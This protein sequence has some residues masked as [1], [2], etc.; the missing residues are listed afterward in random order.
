MTDEEDPRIQPR[1]RIWQ[2]NCRKSLDNMLHLINNL[3]PDHFDLCLVQEP[4][5]D[6]LSRMRAPNG[7]HIVLPP[8]HNNPNT[9]ST[10]PT[11]AV[12]LVS[13]RLDTTGWMN[14]AIESPDATGIQIWGD[15]GTFWIFNVYVDCDHSRTI[16]AIHDWLDS[17]NPDNNSSATRPTAPPAL[18]VHDLLLGDF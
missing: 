16:H 10:S 3:D 1:L 7:W 11:R 12:T 13:P 4:H 6:F 2:Q 17:N 5:I 15:F 9:S 14:L 18:P 8:T